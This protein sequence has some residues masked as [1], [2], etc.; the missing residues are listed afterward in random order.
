MPQVFDLGVETPDKV[1]RRIYLNL[2][3]LKDDDLACHIRDK[4]KIIVSEEEEFVL[5]K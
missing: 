5:N 4:L 1:L 3:K 2:E